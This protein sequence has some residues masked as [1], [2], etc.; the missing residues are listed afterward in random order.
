MTVIDSLRTAVSAAAEASAV[1]RPAGERQREAP[2]HAVVAR[3]DPRRRKNQRG[4][5]IGLVMISPT[6]QARSGERDQRQRSPA[7]TSTTSVRAHAP[8]DFHGG[9]E[10]HVLVDCQRQRYIAEAR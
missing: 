5:T 4:K 6:P 1:R 9:P 3:T 2:D 8:A 7:R 10:F